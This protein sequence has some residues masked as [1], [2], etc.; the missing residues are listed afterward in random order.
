MPSEK[1][2]KTPVPAEQDQFLVAIE[3]RIAALQQLRA[4][5]LAAKSVGAF[6]SPADGGG[7]TMPTAGGVFAGLAGA[8]MELPQ[9][10]LLGKSLPAAIKLYLSAIKKKQSIREIANALRE[11]GVESTAKNFETS[12][13]SAVYRLRDAREV[14]R[15]KDGW[16]LAEFYPESLR[17]SISEKNGSPKPKKAKKRSGK[18]R[19]PKPEA[20]ERHDASPGLEKR[21]ETFLKAQGGPVPASAVAQAT[22]APSNVVGLALGRMKK[23][24]RVTKESDGTYALSK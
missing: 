8:P 2:E 22:S 7:F 16:A 24:G 4:S 21:I 18:S 14:L 10:A 15:F 20:T 19:T 5:Y 13:T 3:A 9:G 11:H 6:G 1:P 23:Q 12:I 17:R